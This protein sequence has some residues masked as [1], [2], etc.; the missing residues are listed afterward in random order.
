MRL[1]LD[2]EIVS[3]HSS[4]FFLFRCW[5]Q[6][7]NRNGKKTPDY[8]TLTL[9]TNNQIFQLSYGLCITRGERDDIET[10]RVIQRSYTAHTDRVHNVYSNMDGPP[11]KWL[12]SQSGNQSYVCMRTVYHIRLRF[13]HRSLNKA[14]PGY[15]WNY[16]YVCTIPHCNND[17]IKKSLHVFW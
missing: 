12:Q 17:E 3:I 9:L 2:G 13:I 16:L 10:E 11:T 5:T 14:G 15:D 8:F 6:S 7:G 1:P 4:I